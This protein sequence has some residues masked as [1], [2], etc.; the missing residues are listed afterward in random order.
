VYLQGLLVIYALSH[1]QFASNQEKF[2]DLSRVFLYFVNC[3]ALVR[4]KDKQA[5]IMVAGV[6]ARSISNI[7]LKLKHQL[8]TDGNY[9]TGCSI[10]TGGKMAFVVTSPKQCIS[11]VKVCSV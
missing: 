6:P 4:R 7:C 10:L 1:V 3:P 8:T 5:Q 2:E 11:V 9:I